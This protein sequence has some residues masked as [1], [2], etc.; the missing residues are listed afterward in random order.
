M[1]GRTLLLLLTVC[2]HHARC[3]PKPTVSMLPKLKEIFIGDL[4]YL[5]CDTPSPVKWYF[6]DE[7][8]LQQTGNAWKFAVAW[9]KH[10]GSYQCE[11]NG[12]KS[13]KFPIDVVDFS[14]M[15]SLTIK[16][17][18]P[19]M[20]G[21]YS[22]ILQLDNEEGLQG[23]RCRVYRRAN[24]TKTIKFKLKSNKTVDIYT[25]I[26]SGVPETIFWCTNSPQS[27][28]SNQII[29]RTSNKAVALEMYP[30][31]AVVG[32]SL[33]L[34]CLAWGTDQISKAVF[35]K[36]D[37][38]LSEANSTFVISNVEEVTQGRYKCEAT[39]TH[40][41][42]ISG[43]PYH[44]I[45]DAQDVLVQALPV[46]AV[47][48]ADNGLLSCSCPRCPSDFSH[49]W[50]YKR[51][52]QPWESIA[53]ASDLMAP[54]S[55]GT[56][57]CRAVR[58]NR[59]SFLSNTYVY[60]SGPNL[61]LIILFILLP[62]AGALI[63][64]AVCYT[65]WKKRHSPGPIY[66]DV[67]L[68]LRDGGDRYETVQKGGREAEYDTLNK[69]AA[70]GERKEADYQ[71]LE[72]GEMKEGVYH[73]L[74]PGEAAGAQGGY[75]ALKKA[76]M[77]EGVYHTLGTEGET[78]AQGGYEALKK[79]EMKEGLYHTLGTEGLTGAQGGYEALKKAGMKEAVYHTLGAEGETGAQGGYEA[80]K[81]A[82]IKEA[83]YHTL[84][85][86]SKVAKD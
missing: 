74:G 77:K 82:G 16:T 6:N 17:G 80:L 44:I 71:A 48:S 4:F 13:D 46:K 22:V 31:P 43:P 61:L 11:H 35:Y 63:C 64:A 1:S 78:V 8:Q 85:E 83:V 12:Q 18:H 69:G 9:P 72:K 28:R 58:N 7:E 75:E 66:E 50:Y 25:T 19:V 5:H 34:K 51:D 47:L 79:A 3:Q 68:K 23:W 42:Y 24:G 27:D 53:G 62:L 59:K 84:S 40:K 52:G 2:A 38:V 86:E 10:S 55:S 29:I 70:G 39:Y 36:D 26:R 65:L 45:S 76:G 81:K 56:Y 15:A 54:R 32:E 73:T 30:L 20:K 33:N 60:D 37:N 41:A 67:A 57:A 14:P 49:R 21:G